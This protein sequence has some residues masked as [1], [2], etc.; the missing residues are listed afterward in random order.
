MTNEPT[1]TELNRMMLIEARVAND[2]K[3]AGLAYVL[4]FFIGG[5]GAQNFYL[6][7][8]LLGLLQLGCAVVGGVMLATGLAAGGTP[9]AAIGIALLAL[10][11]LT[12]IMDLF[13]IPSRVRA[14]SNRVRQ[15]M[16]KELAGTPAKS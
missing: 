2:K 13:L 3:S 4:W 7:K 14:Y 9:S 12:W 15:R 10:L 11:G 16:L 1:N 6:G 5:S 8:P